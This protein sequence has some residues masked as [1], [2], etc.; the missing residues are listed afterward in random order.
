VQHV[1]GVIYFTLWENKIK[2]IICLHSDYS[3][4]T[5]T[6]TKSAFGLKFLLMMVSINL[7]EIIHFHLNQIISIA[8]K[9]SHIHKISMVLDHPCQLQSILI[10]II[11]FLLLH[12]VFRLFGL[13]RLLSSV[14]INKLYWTINY[15]HYCLSYLDTVSKNNINSKT[16]FLH[17]RVFAYI[18]CS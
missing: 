5:I 12:L 15:Y 7:S 8:C 1:T 10:H 2:F 16:I 11:C 17:G 9:T 4:I 13:V 14:Q 18:I 6:A 3:I